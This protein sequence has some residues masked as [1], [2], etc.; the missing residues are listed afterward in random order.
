MD[1]AE[2]IWPPQSNENETDFHRRNNSM[3]QSIHHL[4]RHIELYN[5]TNGGNHP[6]LILKGGRDHQPYRL[7]IL[8]T[9]LC[10]ITPVESS[11]VSLPGTGHPVDPMVALFRHLSTHHWTRERALLFVRFLLSRVE[12]SLD[13][14]LDRGLRQGLGEDILMAL[15]ACEPFLREEEAGWMSR[16]AALEGLNMAGFPPRLQTLGELGHP[17]EEFL[18]FREWKAMARGALDHLKMITH[19]HPQWLNWETMLSERGWTDEANQLIAW[20]LW[21]EL[22]EAY[23]KTG[24]VST[25]KILPRLELAVSL[26][27]SD[28][29]RYGA[30]HLR[31]CLLV[32][33]LHGGMT[34]PETLAEIEK[35]EKQLLD[36]NYTRLAARMESF[37]FH[38]FA[39][40]GVAT[41]LSQLLLMNI[42]RRLMQYDRAGVQFPIRDFLFLNDCK[43]ARTANPT[44]TEELMALAVQLCSITDGHAP[45]VIQSTTPMKNG[46]A[47][48]P[49]VEFPALQE[50]LP[51][52]ATINMRRLLEKPA[53]SIL[54]ASRI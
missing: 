50:A 12:G 54:T 26:L 38:F 24:N 37:R 49:R 18:S 39:R 17:P 20:R 14:H 46:S 16:I 48:K 34:P 11:L 7:D 1:L 53:L 47:H 21:R 2:K 45:Q 43:K 10:P 30:A 44:L 23:E 6:P 33:R 3:R 51:E 42:G 19:L 40:L 32:G 28:D 52:L 9:G 41:N 5:K 36:C 31:A 29:W 35:L 25:L 15:E 22:S 4:R 27:H 8:R 13:T